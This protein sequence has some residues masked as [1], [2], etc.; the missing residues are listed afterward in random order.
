[1]KII[2]SLI[3]ICFGIYTYAQEDLKLF[4]EKTSNGYAIYATNHEFCE[5]SAAVQLGLKNLIS[6]QG[7]HKT[8]VIPAKAKKH[9][10]TQLVIDKKNK[11]YGYNI[12]Y[13]SCLGNSTLTTYD[14][15]YPYFLPYKTNTSYKVHQGY[16]GRFSHK[17]KNA[18][19]F[20]LPLSTGVHAI[21]EG[22]VVK[23]EEKNTK[24]CKKPSCV[25]Y[26]NFIL[27]HHSDGTFA[28]YVHLKKNGAIVNKGDQIE[29]GQL[30]GYSGNTGWS[31]GPHL[32]LQ[33]HQQK[34]NKRITLKT[35]FLTGNGNQL[36]F[37]EERK[38]YKRGY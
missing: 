29:K 3:F 34:I 38:E 11:S 19:D 35:K 12:S 2:T 17:S 37:L 22:I 27:I 16:N 1:M 18:L 5:M 9:L 10:I 32:H 28:S 13:V 25:K 23:I 14:E 7:N 6:T 33:V 20:N 8:F 36:E 31:S 15:N 4:S 30:I 26:G 21:R 24:S